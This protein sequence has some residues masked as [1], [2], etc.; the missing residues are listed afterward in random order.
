[1]LE[2]GDYLFF[3]ELAA[4]HTGEEA[5]KG[6]VP[7]KHSDPIFQITQ[8]KL[9]NNEM[10]IQLKLISSTPSQDALNPYIMDEPTNSYLFGRPF[11]KPLQTNKLSSIFNKDIPQ[12]DLEQQIK[13]KST[14]APIPV[15][16]DQITK[17]SISKQYHISAIRLK[18]K[19]LSHSD[20]N[21]TLLE[22]TFNQ[23][24]GIIIKTP[25][26]EEKFLDLNIFNS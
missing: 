19:I 8:F 20:Q 22:F 26:Q 7:A 2:V 5:L 17:I 1:M 16:N 25:S 9:E 6:L 23:D 4:N 15:E 21:K 18:F 24:Y 3:T 12:T 11:A 13:K 14:P 10:Q